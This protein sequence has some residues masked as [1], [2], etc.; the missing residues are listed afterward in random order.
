VI[1]NILLTYI[2]DKRIC[3]DTN[4][5]KAKKILEDKYKD[6]I[7]FELEIVVHDNL[8][9]PFLLTSVHRDY[10]YK[11]MNDYDLVMYSEDDI[12]ITYNSILDFVDKLK[13]LWPTYIPCFKRCEYSK[14]KKH[15]IMGVTTLKRKLKRKRQGQTARVI[16]IKQLSAK[17]V[18]KNVDVEA[19]KA[20]FAK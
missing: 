3:I 16:K 14:I 20:S 12:L 2:C 8:E 5:H 18:I 13:D 9:H 19:I 6:H 15:T 10:I 7:G 11:H 17:P 1:D 4:S